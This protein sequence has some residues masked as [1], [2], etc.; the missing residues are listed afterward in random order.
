MATRGSRA[1][2]LLC[3]IVFFVSGG[4]TLVCFTLKMIHR[5]KEEPCAQ[6]LPLQLKLLGKEQHFKSRSN[7]AHKEGLSL[8]VSDS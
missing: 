7:K 2:A 4:H 1:A 8:Y 5:Y 3:V 6:H